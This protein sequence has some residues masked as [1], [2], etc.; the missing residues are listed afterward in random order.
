MTAARI[1][2]SRR[3]N[4]HRKADIKGDLKSCKKIREFRKIGL[5]ASTHDARNVHSE[6][7]GDQSSPPYEI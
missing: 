5:Q 7:V 4:I 3:T 6:E 2:S 1:A